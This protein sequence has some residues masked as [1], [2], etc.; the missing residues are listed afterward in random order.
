MQPIFHILVT[1]LNLYTVIAASVGPQKTLSD[2]NK[3][4]GSPFGVGFDLTASYG[5]AA[6]SFPNGT[7]V[8]VA[9]IQAEQG[10]NDMLQRLSRAASQ[11]PSPPYNNVGESWDDMPRQYLRKARKAVGLPASQD[12]GNLAKMLSGL[13]TVVEESV[14]P[15]TTA[16]VTTMHLP[17]LY[18]EDLHDAF[19]Y[20]GLKYITFPVGYV[21]HNILYETSAAFAGYGYGL[22]TDYE[23]NPEA[24]KN[25]QWNM[26]DQAIM[27]VVYT[28]TALS[29][30]LSV[31]R[32]AYALWE[33]PYRYH[34]DFDLGYQASLSS[35]GQYWATLE[36]KLG[37]ILTENPNYERPS[38]VMLMGDRIEELKFRECLNKVLN[39][40][41]HERPE[42]L[43]NN[44]REVAAKGAAEMAKREIFHAPKNPSSCS[45]ATKIEK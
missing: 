12:V 5:S 20:L 6:V 30:S 9:H 25:E 11:H 18:D 24:C 29:V 39:E 34:A 2:S 13:R 42:V 31:I 14:G 1:A 4:S 38:M 17:A 27:A 10:Y 19:E 32:S 37:E 15:I 23:S 35:T 16:A 22:C 41:M 36:L 7:V 8:T 45:K 44:G 43:S 28:D 21:G 33:P 3:F 26:T 40:Q